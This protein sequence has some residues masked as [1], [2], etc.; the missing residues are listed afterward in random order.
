LG[1]PK[2]TF[3]ILYSVLGLPSTFL[4][5]GCWQLKGQ[6]PVSLFDMDI[7]GRGSE[8]ACSWCG[9]LL[10]QWHKIKSSSLTLQTGGIKHSGD[11]QG[12]TGD[13]AVPMLVGLVLPKLWKS[14]ESL[15]RE[16]FGD[17]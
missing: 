14:P 15:I 9:I 12:C 7:Q 3:K 16:A 1:S 8:F 4:Q 6:I 17:K 11:V 5:E 13:L 2:R 10:S